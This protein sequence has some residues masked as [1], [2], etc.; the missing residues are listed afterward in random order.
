MDEK[1]PFAQGPYSNEQKVILPGYTPQSQ[2]QYADQT[3]MFNPQS[4]MM[5]ARNKSQNLQPPMIPAKTHWR[6]DPAYQV[7]L[8]AIILI[9]ISGGIFTVVATNLFKN[10]GFA[11]GQNNN[12]GSSY[13]TAPTQGVQRQVNVQPTFPPP[14]ST[15]TDTTGNTISSQPPQSGTPTMAVATETVTVT[16]SPTDTPPTNQNGP[17]NLQIV[18]YP[19]QISNN[20]TALIQVSTGRANAQVQLSANYDLPPFFYQGTS[21]ITDGNGNT[22]IFWPINLFGPATRHRANNTVARF[23]VRAQSQDGQVATSSMITIQVRLGAGG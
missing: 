16:L 23:V 6:N 10:M 7:L 5:Q 17:L 14:G 9:I 11:D 2:D 8:V 22:T 19:Q 15:P 21:Q 1:R 13:Q 18:S 3:E 4:A 20:M 12:Q